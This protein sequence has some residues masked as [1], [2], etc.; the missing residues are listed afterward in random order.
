M[1][2]LYSDTVS[3]NLWHVLVSR[4]GGIFFLY[5]LHN[6]IASNKGSALYPSCKNSKKIPDNWTRSWFILVAPFHASYLHVIG[7]PPHPYQSPLYHYSKT[8]LFPTGLWDDMHKSAGWGCYSFTK[9]V[10]T[11]LS[12]FHD[13]ECLIVPWDDR[14]KGVGFGGGLLFSKVGLHNNVIIPWSHCTRW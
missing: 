6:N 10:C 3:H 14:H 7:F 13:E 8:K 12:L 5:S 2:S 4:G 1:H 11:T 9:W